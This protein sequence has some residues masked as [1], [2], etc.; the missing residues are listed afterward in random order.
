MT[1]SRRGEGKSTMKILKISP[2]RQKRVS[3]GASRAQMGVRG[4]RVKGKRVKKL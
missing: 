3:L 4:V 1:L 2:V